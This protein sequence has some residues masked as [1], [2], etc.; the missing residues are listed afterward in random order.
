MKLI[1]NFFNEDFLR[2]VTPSQIINN[3]KLL[4]DNYGDRAVM[5][6]LHMLYENERVNKQLE[7]LHNDDILGFIRTIN[8]SGNS[9]YKY[10]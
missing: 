5:R 1:A 6:A 8:E 10:L 2:Y 9:S 4:R 7:N 3:A